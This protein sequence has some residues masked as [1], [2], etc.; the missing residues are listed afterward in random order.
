M[1]A[2]AS[3]AYPED[4]DRRAPQDRQ[5]LNESFATSTAHCERW[6]HSVTSIDR[7][8]LRKK[9]LELHDAQGSSLASVD[10]LTTLLRFMR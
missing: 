4:E 2:V 10:E 3:T 1:Q 6:M 5:P 9:R 8:A 7:R